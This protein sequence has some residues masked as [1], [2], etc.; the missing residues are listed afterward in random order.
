MC[1]NLCP[2]VVAVVVLQKEKSPSNQLVNIL[3]VPLLFYLYV[4]SQDG[5]YF[6]LHEGP[7]HV[8][9]DQRA[10]LTA[11]AVHLAGGT[12]LLDALPGAGEAEL[13]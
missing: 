13:V 5:G 7:G 11:G 3:R 6:S 10:P 4:P 12:L 8:G 9:A 1:L 2:A